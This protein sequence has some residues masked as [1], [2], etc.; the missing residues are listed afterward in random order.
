VLKIY[1]LFS[2][3]FWQFLRRIFNSASFSIFFS[4]H[5]DTSS[6]IHT[7]KEAHILSIY[8]VSPIRCSY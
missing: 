8:S 5:R 7:S 6:Q 4:T 3:N 1:K 2:Y